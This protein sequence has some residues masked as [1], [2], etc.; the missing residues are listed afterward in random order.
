MRASTAA[1]LIF[2]LTPT[3][4]PQGKLVEVIEVRVV[5]VDVVVRDRSGNP[6]RGLTK[7]DFDLYEDRVKQTITNLYEVRRDEVAQPVQ[8]SEVQSTAPSVPIELRQRRL[9]LFVDSSS[10]QYSRKQAVLDA[11]DKFVNQ[12]MQPEDQA[13]LV[14]WQ[15]GLHVVTPFTS[16]KEVLKHGIVALERYA[17]TGQSADHAIVQLKREIQSWIDRALTGGTRGIGWDAAY[18]EALKVVDVY[19]EQLLQ[20]QGHMLDALRRMIGNLAGLEGKK[21]LLFISQNL[22]ERP[23]AEFFRYTYDQ[24]A[25]HMNRTNPLDLQMLSGAI[26]NNRPQQIEELSKKASIDGVIIYAIDAQID[27][28][29]SAGEGTLQVD[30]GESFSRHANTASSLQTMADITG[31]V[32][33]TQTSNYDLAFDTISH[34]LDSYYSLGYKPAGEGSINARKIV[35]K[36]KDRTYIVRARESFVLK[37]TDEQMSDRVI[38][39]LF[40]DASAS[41][42]PISIRT[43][44]PKQDGRAFLV[45]IE[46]VMPSTITLLPQEQNLAGAFTL[47]FVVGTGDGLTS[48]VMRRPRDLHIPASAEPLVR[49]KPM[50]FSTAIRVNRGESTL[51][52]GIVDQVSGATGYARMKIIAQ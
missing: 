33:I 20:E 43:G 19:S 10:I 13:M 52:V 42:W 45:P 24:F 38:A 50:T 47:Y 16:D 26:G 6:V 27:S 25:P 3:A 28:D 5:N 7:D 46:V 23:G 32:A 36:T 49:A 17:P 44:R 15:L 30:Y 31:G 2:L 48:D 51:S 37:S 39:N 18:A 21:A 8:A 22:P 1:I 40:T 14:T 29:L 11:A 12:R 34:D 35:V 9:L 4:F 41:T